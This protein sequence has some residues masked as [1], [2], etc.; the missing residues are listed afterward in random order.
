MSGGLQP[1]IYAHERPLAWLFVRD[2]L[3][4][5]CQ[6]SIG[7]WVVGNDNQVIAQ[8]GQL[9]HNASYEGLAVDRQ[10]SLAVMVEGRCPKPRALP[11]CQ[12]NRAHSQ[13]RERQHIASHEDSITEKPAPIKLQEPVVLV[14]ICRLRL[15][16]TAV[17]SHGWLV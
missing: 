6:R 5:Q 16:R 3:D 17:Q 11:P 10:E 14:A 13:A 4:W 2:K 7:S 1:G 15:L 8:S 12:N 9:V